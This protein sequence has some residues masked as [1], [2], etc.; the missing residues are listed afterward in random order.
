MAR[1]DKL[2]EQLRACRGPFPYKDLVTLLG[3]LGYEQVR[4]GKTGGSRRRFAHPDTGDVI[5]IHAPH[6]KEIKAYA[7]RDVR[8]HLEE[9]GLL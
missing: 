5:M 4:G 7:V 9:R 6:S 3:Q 1:G 8:E 2:K